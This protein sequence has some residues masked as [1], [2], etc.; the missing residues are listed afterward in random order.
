[1][2]PP[3]GDS[4]ASRHRIELALTLR[5]SVAGLLSF[6]V[7]HLFQVTQVYWAVLTTV[8]VMQA[9]VGG[10]LK[11]MLD[12]FVG[13]LGGAGWG[14]AVTIA[15]PHPDVASTGIALAAA[16]IPLALLVAFR[17]AYRVAPVTAAI[18]LLGRPV[19]GGVIA[20]ALDRVFE[21]GLGSIVA[22]AV[23]LWLAP[24][25]AHQALYA[26]G[27]D[28]LV[29]MAAQIAGL[30]A[31]MTAPVD[32]VATLA[33]HDRARGAIERAAAAADETARERRSYVSD[34][35]DPEPLVR[36]LRRLSHDLVIIG[37]ALPALLPTAAGD[38]LCRP[39]ADLAAVL[40]DYMPAMGD[41]LIA[42][43]APPD[44]TPL[45][46]AFDAYGAAVAA[47]RHAGATHA[48][49]DD[50][51]ERIFGLSFGLEQLRSNLTDMA[52]RVSELARQ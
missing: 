49:S 47:L 4:W 11:A 25:R 35:P 6:A 44:E 48:L 32:R 22:L 30:L 17:P 8:I 18:V 10:S 26:A 31:G 24:M 39:A 19:A 34:T 5:M 21:I 46:R 2:A 1:M 14:V 3:A 36:T 52:A 45:S 23:A 41:S 50:D 29:A 27:R 42:G 37:R 7:A 15:L 43:T 38:H 51:V 9:S 28:A 40:C 20:A 13:T 12:R 33:L 16:L